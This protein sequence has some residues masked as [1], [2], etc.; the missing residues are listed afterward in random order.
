M[1]IT[2]RHP[3]IIGCNVQSAVETEYHLIIAHE[4]TNVGPDRNA[5]SN[6]ANQA[7]Q[8]IG[9]KTIDVVADKGYYKGQTR[10]RYD[11]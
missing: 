3:R 11:Q 5:L 8:T 2:S 4:L 9:V 7:R 1:A 10:R 6:M